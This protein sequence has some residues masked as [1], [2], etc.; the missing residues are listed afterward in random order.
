ML[1]LKR[2]R[3]AEEKYLPSRSTPL[4]SSKFSFALNHW[5]TEDH[6][7]RT[8]LTNVCYVARNKFLHSKAQQAN[9]KLGRLG[10]SF[11]E[12]EILRH[13]YGNTVAQLLQTKGSHP[14]EK[15]PPYSLSEG[16]IQHISIPYTKPYWKTQTAEGP[17]KPRVSKNSRF[18]GRGRGESPKTWV[19]PLYRVDVLRR[20]AWIGWAF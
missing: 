20:E 7:N 12:H 16:E 3:H 10:A 2:G 8:E 11:T 18:R 1:K 14:Q 15:R 19:R 13:F 9:E 6:A 17:P 4:N 5:K